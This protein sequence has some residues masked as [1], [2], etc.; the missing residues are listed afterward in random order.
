MNAAPE[1]PTDTTIAQ[2]LAQLTSDTVNGKA[3]KLALQASLPFNF[4]PTS[5]VSYT[6]NGRLIILGNAANTFPVAEQLMAHLTCLIVL[7]TTEMPPPS[8]HEAIKWCYGD[9]EHVEGHLGHFTVTIEN[10]GHVFNAASLFAVDCSYAD[11]VLDLTATPY[12]QREIPPPG[13]YAPQDEA[14]LD[15]ALQELPDLQG[16][17]DKP[18]FFNYDPNICAHGNSGQ[19]GCTRCIEACPTVAIR[20][21]G[22]TIAVNPNL[23]QGGGSCATACPSGAITYAYPKASDTLNQLRILL[24]T[25]FH[26]E[27]KHPHLVFFD[28]NLLEGVQQFCGQWDEHCI[29][30]AIE[31]IGAVG[32]DCWF[33]SLAYGARQITLLYTPETAPAVIRELTVQLTY[34]NSILAGMG[35]PTEVIRLVLLASPAAAGQLADGTTLPELPA[36]TFAGLDEKRKTLSLAIAHL[37]QQAPNPTAEVMLPAGAPFG[38]VVVNQ[39]A[40]TLCMSCV[41]VCPVNALL[42]GQDKPQLRFNESR[43]VQCGICESA[44]PEDAIQLVPRLIYDTAVRQQ[45]RLLNEE[46]PFHCIKCGKPFAT[47]TMINR[48]TEKLKDHAMYQGEALERL[49][50]CEDCRVIVM[51]ENAEQ[52]SEPEIKLHS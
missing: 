38:E 30:Y 3:R 24:K 5:L 25:Y 20:S 42:D 1:L 34:A 47:E 27:G 13:Y 40:C 48:M 16:E 31:E 39:E 14:S 23:C 12:I 52:L 41:T 19:Q 21:L 10:S 15:H 6:S 7:P 17:F 49:Q 35:Y 8:S 36:A 26:A 2:A 9:V 32:M 22:D 44:C 46:K 37:Y 33:A 18:K 51:L 45:I 29:P 43:C 50:M 11:L 4:Q 28:S